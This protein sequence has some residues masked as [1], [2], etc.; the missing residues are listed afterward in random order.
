MRRGNIASKRLLRTSSL[1]P[2]LVAL[3]AIQAGGHLAASRTSGLRLL[4]LHP[5]R[6]ELSLKVN[7]SSA[8]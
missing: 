5:L 8:G 6:H 1:R 2:P 7:E 3:L 4:A